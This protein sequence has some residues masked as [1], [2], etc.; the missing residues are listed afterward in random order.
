MGAFFVN[1][2]VIEPVI[3]PFLNVKPSFY[4]KIIKEDSMMSEGN[5]RKKPY[6]S[7]IRSGK[8]ESNSLPSASQHNRELFRVRASRLVDLFPDEL[9]IQEKTISIIRNEFLVSYI[10]TIPVKDIG[11][12]VY[13]DAPFFARIE[14]LG[15]NPAHD[16]F[17]RGLPK[18]QAI[19]AQDILNGLLLEKAYDAENSDWQHIDTHRDAL[20][21]SGSI[22][23]QSR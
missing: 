2:E 1:K 14:V 9:V 4:N 3:N 11:R 15:K 23:R 16:L 8:T 6:P 13:V 10:E 7:Q 22:Y 18:K 5:D 21:R 20:T 17:I 19:I 12:I